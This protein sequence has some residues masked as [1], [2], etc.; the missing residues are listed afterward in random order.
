MHN[1]VHSILIK[2]QWTKRI[3]LGKPVNPNTY[4][5]YSNY[6]LQNT[7]QSF[8]LTGILYF[9]FPRHLM[10]TLHPINITPFLT[11]TFYNVAN[12]SA[13]MR[14]NVVWSLGHQRGKF[15]TVIVHGKRKAK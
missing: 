11:H 1:R 4:K 2:L 3:G 10:F 5:N 8:I 6:A 13:E 12:S 7:L 14:C 9:T 15:F